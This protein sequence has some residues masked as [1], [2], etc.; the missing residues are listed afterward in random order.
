MRQAHHFHLQLNS[1]RRKSSISMEKRRILVIAGSDSS[2][3]AFVL[4]FQRLE[5]QGAEK[6]LPVD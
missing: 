2:G 1:V 4:T 5:T 3:G 6:F